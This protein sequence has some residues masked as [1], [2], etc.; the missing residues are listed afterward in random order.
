VDFVAHRDEPPVE[1][2]ALLGE[3]DVGPAEPE[4]LV[5][6]HPGHRSEP[7]DGEE[8]VPDCGAHKQS[9]LVVGQCHAF[10]ALQRVLL[11]GACDDRDVT[12]HKPSTV[13]VGE[14]ATDDE[15]DLVHGLG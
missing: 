8:P 14:R 13:R 1:V 12:G 11:G 7:E 3:V 10:D 4:D 2:Q 15:V 5:A 9:E 6:A